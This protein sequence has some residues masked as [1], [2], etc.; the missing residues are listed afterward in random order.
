MLVLP[1]HYSCNFLP[2]SVYIWNSRR[3]ICPHLL[4]QF[5]HNPHS[6]KS[7]STKAASVGNWLHTHGCSCG[8]LKILC[9]TEKKP[10]LVL[11]MHLQNF[12]QKHSYMSTVQIRRERFKSSNYMYTSVVQFTNDHTFIMFLQVYMS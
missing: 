3:I 12:V 1:A 8:L 10:T 11:H 7:H 4:D 6:H 5:S 2:C 9:S